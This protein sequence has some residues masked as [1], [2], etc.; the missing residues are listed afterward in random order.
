MELVYSLNVTEEG[1]DHDQM[2]DVCMTLPTSD[3]VDELARSMSANFDDLMMENPGHSI[4]LY[5]E[6]R[7]PRGYHSTLL[8]AATALYRMMQQSDVL[9][10]SVGHVRTAGKDGWYSLPSVPKLGVRPSEADLHA[11]V[12][13][14]HSLSHA[15]SQPTAKVKGVHRKQLYVSVPM[16][17]SA[18]AKGT[19]LAD[20]SATSMRN[21]VTALCSFHLKGNDQP[22]LGFVPNYYAGDGQGKRC[23]VVSTNAF[24]NW[25]AVQGLVFYPHAVGA[26]SSKGKATKSDISLL[27]MKHDEGDNDSL[28]GDTATPI[29]RPLE[30]DEC[31]LPKLNTLL[32]SQKLHVPLTCYEDYRQYWD[33][34]TNRPRRLLRPVAKGLYRQF[35]HNESQGGRLSGHPIQQLPET[36][37]QRLTIDGKPTKE[38]DYSSMQLRLLYAAAGVPLIGR[39][40]LYVDP[41]QTFTDDDHRNHHRDL[42]K[43]VLLHSVGC[44]T[45]AKTVGS[46]QQML[47]DQSGS[48]TMEQALKLYHQL[49]DMHPL[50][51]PHDA[52]LP[53]WGRLQKLESQIA[54]RVLS[55][56]LDQGI[57]G[58]P[59]HDSFIVQK[60]YEAQLRAAMREAFEEIASG[61]ECKIA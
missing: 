57:A 31:I 3:Q 23:S 42:M 6:I 28:K 10:S 33:Y 37:R 27:W 14:L 21:M 25:M 35:K 49:W 53:A 54:L 45:K 26:K 18:Y 61:V 44:A 43:T 50:A 2:S 13:L 34:T 59:I 16:S 38:L 29:T 58:I 60:R 4:P 22:W 30:G 15:L 48:A 36:E 52:D 19:K 1:L 11:L 55:K 47:K 32:T 7:G 39:G 46:L 5:Y 40:D 41:G 51:C 12:H 20:I 56:L 24:N 8:K 9:K 17:A